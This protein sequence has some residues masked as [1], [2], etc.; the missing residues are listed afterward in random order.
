LTVYDSRRYALINRWDQS[1]LERIDRLVDISSGDRVLEVGCGRGHLTQAIAARGVDIVGV[2]ANPQAHDVAESDLVRHMFAENLDF[3]DGT[4]DVIVSVHA[5]EHIPHLEQALSEMARVLK[6]GGSAV[7]IYP[8]EPIQGLFAIP[9]AIILHGNPLKAREVHCH[10]L[11]PAKLRDLFEP[12][13][14]TETG[15]EF[16]LFKSPQFASVFEKVG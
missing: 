3:D 7:H 6:P 11:W 1:H 12:F 10:K 8:A 2:D 13:G 15:H 5:I 4:F 9:T 14:M 16:S